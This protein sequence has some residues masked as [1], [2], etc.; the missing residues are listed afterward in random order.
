[1]IGYFSLGLCGYEVATLDDETVSY[2]F[3]G[4]NREQLTHKAKIYYNAKGEP[5]FK[6]KY[7]RIYLHDCMRKDV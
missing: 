5:Y 6:T 1:M 7:R 3:I 2:I 4:T